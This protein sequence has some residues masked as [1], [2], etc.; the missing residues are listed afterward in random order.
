MDKP[1]H[2][3]IASD[4]HYAGAAEKARGTDYE[5]S[6]I[7]HPLTKLF[8]RLFR[9]VVWLKDPFAHAHL[10]NRLL[11]PPI[12]PDLVILNGDYSCDSAFIGVSDPASLESA[13][14]VLAKLRARFGLRVRPTFG[15]HELGKRSLAGE[16]GGLRLASFDL[17]RE[18]LGIPPFWKQSA[19]R[20]LLFGVT[21]SLIAFP[22]FE[23]EAL[24]EER[25]RWWAL[26]DE[27]FEQVRRAF[28]AVEPHQKIL[29]F[30]HD[31]T[32]LPYMHD[33][34]VIAAKLPQIERTI[35]GHLH[36]PIVLWKSR[37]LSGMPVIRFCGNAVRR[38]SSALHRAASW[39]PFNV[40]LCP[41]LAGVELTKKGGFY[42]AI[43]DPASTE[44]LQFKFHPI[45]WR[46]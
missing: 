13:A 33:D 23:K 7:K 8:I 18:R 6:I 17:A 41:S 31:P 15:D 25:A 36:T 29:L 10:V 32:A 43:I 45:K 16:R 11:E 5:L 14:E 34:P 24:P 21:S 38:M 12:E 39:K 26:R 46:A 40:L 22:V 3:L 20:Y 37:I 4:L 27:H 1:I 28:A 2:L 44:P 30:C 42:T 9:Q 35:I 19:G